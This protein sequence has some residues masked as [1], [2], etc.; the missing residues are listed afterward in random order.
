MLDDSAKIKAAASFREATPFKHIVLDEFFNHDIALELSS[1]FPSIDHPAWKRYLNP[2]ENKYL[3]NNWDVFSTLTYKVFTELNSFAFVRELESLTG[4]CDLVSD[5]GLHGGGLHMHGRNGILNV[6]LDYSI[7]PKLMLQR[8]LNLLVYL[9]PDWDP[10][11]GGELQ[12]WR[13]DESRPIEVQQVIEPRFN[14]AVLF[15]TTANS[16]HG[17]PEPIDCP[18]SVFRRSIALYYLSRPDS[19]HVANRKKA[20]FSPRPEQEGDPDID[21]LIVLRSDVESVHKAYET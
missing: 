12:L 16:W 20:T 17:L 19:S 6:H 5:H 9:T 14:R 11:W 13:G 8:R 4:I 2:L 15:D 3:T 18:D 21:K 10:K 7:H 1:E